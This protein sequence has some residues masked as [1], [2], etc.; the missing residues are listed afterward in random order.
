MHA[1]HGLKLLD[2]VLKNLLLKRPDHAVGFMVHEICKATSG[3]LVS[4]GENALYFQVALK[5]EKMLKGLPKN[6]RKHQFSC[7]QTWKK[8]PNFVN[9]LTKVRELSR[10]MLTLNLRKFTNFVH[11][12]SHWITVTVTTNLVVNLAHGHDDRLRAW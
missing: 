7:K 9:W 1:C 5:I 3:I 11:E 8:I 6:V 10:T 4:P 2:S 12:L